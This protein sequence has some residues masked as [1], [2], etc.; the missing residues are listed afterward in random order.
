MVGMLV[1]VKD[2]PLMQST[3]QIVLAGELQLG[4]AMP[5]KAAGHGIKQTQVGC[6][7]DRVFGTVAISVPVL[8]G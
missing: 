7:I 2:C 1:K 3:L 6:R 8:T 4:R 5:T